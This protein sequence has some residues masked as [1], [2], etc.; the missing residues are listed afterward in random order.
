[1]PFAVFSNSALA[2][3]EAL[4]T[5]AEGS[6]AK[7]GRVGGISVAVGSEHR[8]LAYL[9]EAL[10]PLAATLAVDD[11]RIHKSRFRGFDELDDFY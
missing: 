4:T 9:A 2:L 3:A 6:F 10:L 8:P 5:F 11:A 1:M 7:R